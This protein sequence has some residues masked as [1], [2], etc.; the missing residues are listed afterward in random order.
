MYRQPEEQCIFNLI[1]RPERA[2]VKAKMYRSKFDPTAPVVASTFGDGRSG[3]DNG[4]RRPKVGA[5][6]KPLG[7]SKP[8]PSDYLKGRRQS[9]DARA[10]VRDNKPFA[11]T[12]PRKAGVPRIGDRPV[13]GLQSTKN[14]V[15][16]NAVEAILA[17][18]G[19]RARVNELA[20]HYR[21]KVDY[22][23]VPGYLADVKDEIQKE[24]KMI[25]QYLGSENNQADVDEGDDMPDSE[26]QD[27]VNKLKTK[28]GETNS[29]YQKI[30]HMVKLDTIG[31]VRRKEKYESEL[32]QLEKD[33]EKL[34][35]SRLVIVN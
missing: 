14:Y 33:I 2:S 28:W 25:E 8:D 26:I 22:G 6:G 4:K 11:R 31:K 1:P 24:N 10:A 15:T 21:H 19:N 12:G 16:A 5:M 7:T 20:P 32:T 23:K 17:V 18:P 3:M 34:E 27:L 9:A 13:M 30:C 35:N 29:K